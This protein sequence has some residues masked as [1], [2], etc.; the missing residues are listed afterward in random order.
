M[1]TNRVPIFSVA[2]RL[3]TVL[4]ALMFSV[5]GCGIEQMGANA[6]APQYAPRA[7]DSLLTEGPVFLDSVEVKAADDQ[8]GTALVHLQGS[9]PS[10]CHALRAQ[11]GQPDGDNQIALHVYSV[12]NPDR[13]C[14][15]VIVFFD[16]IHPIRG[17]STD[18][19]YVVVVNGQD[20]LR[21]DWP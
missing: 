16:A 5:A 2:R 8:A 1:N 20:R 21:L 3:S 14:A 10:P 11:A 15:G 18:R 13:M 6:S 4:F 19:E 7:G 9:V 12:F 17:L